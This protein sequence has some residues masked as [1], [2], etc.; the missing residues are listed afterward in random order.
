MS[1]KDKMLAKLAESDLPEA[2]D[3]GLFAKFSE[4]G[5]SVAG[6][7]EAIEARPKYRS[8]EG[9]DWTVTLIDGEE[10][11]IITANSVDLQRKVHPNN[12]KIGDEVL[13]QFSDKK[14]VGQPQPMKIFAV[15]VNDEFAPATKREEIPEPIIADDTNEPF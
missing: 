14:D 12:M 7:V 1:I 13:I 3:S 9:N 11:K 5:D 8:E 2:K 10:T 4:V 6:V 15:L